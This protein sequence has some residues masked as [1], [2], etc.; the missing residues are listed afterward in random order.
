MDADVLVISTAVDAIYRDFGE[1]N[2]KK[3]STISSD[4]ARQMIEQEQLPPGSMGPKVEAM[5]HAR[6]FS[7]E[8][9]VVLCQPGEAISAVRGDSGTT[10]V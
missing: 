7:D 10:L 1:V 6:E 5:L 2:Q 3:L 9:T 8:M 4:E